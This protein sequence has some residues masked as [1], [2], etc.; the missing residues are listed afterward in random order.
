MPQ[1]LELDQEEESIGGDSD[2]GEGQVIYVQVVDEE[3]A[4]EPPV[5]SV[6]TSAPDDAVVEEAPP[7]GTPMVTI[8]S[9]SA[10]SFGD[11]LVEPART[12]TIGGVEYPR[13]I[14]FDGVR[15]DKVL[16]LLRCPW[17]H[18]WGIGADDG[19]DRLKEDALEGYFYLGVP[20][21]LL[22]TC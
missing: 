7:G 3:H 22:R 2:G 14:Q 15:E 18:R 8:R 13:P 19:C 16:N 6:L 12:V 17:Y 10:S 9:N 1:D 20:Y 5:L 11:E 21:E 4:R